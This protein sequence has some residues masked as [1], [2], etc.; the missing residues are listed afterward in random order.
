MIAAPMASDNVAGRPRSIWPEHADVLGVGLDAAVE[1]L[2][3]RPVVLDVDRLVEAVFL[4]GRAR[5]SAAVAVRPASRSAGSP[6]G[7]AK[8]IRNVSTLT[9]NSTTTAEAS[10]LIAKKSRSIAQRSARMRARGS[11]ACRRPSPKMFTDSTATTSMMPGTRVRCGALVM[12]WRAVGQHRAP[13]RVGRLNAGAEERQAGLEHDR[14]RQLQREEHDQR[15]GQVG[16]DLAEHD[17]QPAV[18][19]GAGRVD[20]LPFAQRQHLTAHRPGDVG[21]VDDAD[22]ERRDEVRPALDV[23]RADGQPADRQADAERDA[24]QQGRIGPDQVEQ[25]RDD[26]VGPAAEEAG[27]RR[28]G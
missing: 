4:A 17:P 22:D 11:K 7:I 21:D 26:D 19:E 10:R 5:S 16:Q 12:S 20:E 3:H 24:E 25:A 9:A 14:L 23:Q 13:G 1:D 27:R 8:K 15:R 6:F 18:A 2:L 28:P